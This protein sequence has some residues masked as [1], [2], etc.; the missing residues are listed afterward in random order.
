MAFQD[1]VRIIDDEE[2]KLR[3]HRGNR[4]LDTRVF[5]TCIFKMLQ[6]GTTW[7]N[8]GDLKGVDVHYQTVYKRFKKLGRQGF[9]KNMWDRLLETY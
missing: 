9:M 5:L 1:G 8:L 4:K 6:R 7:R 2:N 3:V